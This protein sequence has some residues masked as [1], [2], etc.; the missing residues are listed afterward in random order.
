MNRINII[1]LGVKNMERAIKFYRDG[2]GFK[3]DEMNNNPDIIFFSNF[4]TKLA[5]YPLELLAEDIDS[6]NPP[7]AKSG[8]SGIT[9]AYNTKTKAEVIKVTCLAK[10][11]G[12]TIIKDPQ[13]VF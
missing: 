8:F 10:K 13:E 3:T 2:L 7:F 4:G 1:T 5:L 12:A 9:L 6:D 11:A